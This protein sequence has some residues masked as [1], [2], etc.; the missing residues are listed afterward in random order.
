M[1]AYQAKVVLRGPR[2][3][4]ERQATWRSPRAGAPAASGRPDGPGQGILAGA[5]PN[6]DFPVGML[7]MKMNDPPA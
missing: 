5:P 3:A 7:A 2:R 4:R 6:P 1:Q